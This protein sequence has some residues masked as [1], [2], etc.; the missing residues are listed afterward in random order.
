MT[1]VQTPA[2]NSTT[3]NTMPS[4]GPSK[5]CRPSPAFPQRPGLKTS[6]RPPS[7]ATNRW[8]FWWKLLAR[9]K[10]K[11]QPTFRIAPRTSGPSSQA[12]S[13]HR[14]QRKKTSRKRHRQKLHASR[15]CERLNE[16]AS[17]HK[18]ASA[19]TNGTPNGFVKDDQYNVDLGDTTDLSSGCS[20]LTSAS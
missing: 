11:E 3:T 18:R 4:V 12:V 9:K 20:S 15:I 1:Q 14:A 13:N 16:Y 8:A 6:P 19:A 10:R 17:S 2:V 5:T 7:G